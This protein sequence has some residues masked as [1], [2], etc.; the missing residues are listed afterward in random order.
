MLRR[1]LPLLALTV[2]SATLPLSA[3]IHEGEAPVDL[4]KGLL[5]KAEAA[6]AEA[7]LAPAAET[8]PG[9]KSFAAALLVEF[10]D[11]LKD[12]VL[13]SQSGEKQGWRFLVTAAGALRFE[14]RTTDKPDAI[15]VT[16]Q[17]G[18]IAPG[19]RHHLALNILREAGKPNA[20]LWVDGIEVASGVMPPVNLATSEPLRIAGAKQVRLYHRELSRPEVIALHLEA[21]ASGQ[22]V[23]KHPEPPPGGPLFIP[24]PGETIA[25]IGGTEAVALAE[26]GEL[27]ALLLMSFPQ[28][29]FHF[30]SLA[31]EGDTVFRQDRPLNFG[32]LEQQ[33][34]RV[35]AGTVFVMFGRQECLE[36]GR[37]KAE[38]GSDGLAEFKEAFGKLLDTVAKVTPNIVVIGPPPFEKKEPPLPDLSIGNQDL[39]DYSEM[40]HGIADRH[41]VIF[42]D[43]VREVRLMRFSDGIRH[44]TSDGVTFNDFGRT[45]LVSIF[46]KSLDTKFGW[47]GDELPR[48]RGLHSAIAAKNRLWHD[49][50]RPSNWAFLF[51]D[52]TQ[53]PSSR[54]PVNPQIRFFPA[55]Q[56]KYLPLLKDAEEKV[57][58]LVEEAAKRLP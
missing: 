11:P 9:Q 39:G 19:S 14:A 4:A 46:L 53:Q 41:G 34:R 1:Q 24:Q 47:T 15:T 57:F 32:S 33:L 50:W 56:E 26:S 6:S 16:T 38:G 37:R 8:Q 28:T 54:D 13:A 42:A 31:W 48:V 51:G 7:T 18:V 45:A 40:L 29:R 30:R 27:E 3:Q 17:P 58:K 52:R 2:L 35:N 22:P 49:Y 5:L 12:T 25:L 36:G 21:S 43:L 20:G 55:E 10:A 44:W 23:A